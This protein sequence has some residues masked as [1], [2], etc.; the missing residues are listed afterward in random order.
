MSKD[1]KLKLYKM[2][3]NIED[4]TVLNQLMEEVAFYTTKNDIVDELNA[5]QLEEL[6]KAI[7]EANKGETILWDEFKR[8]M[9]EWKKNNRFQT[10]S[11]RHATGISIFAQRIFRRHCF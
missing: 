9:N 1:A 6:D 7:E 3:D 11:Q 2:L 10:L 5:K 4:E 8:E